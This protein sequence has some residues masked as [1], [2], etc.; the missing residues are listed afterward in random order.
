MARKIFSKS[1][2]APA[3]TRADMVRQRRNRPAAAA[4]ASV[5]MRSPQELLIARQRRIKAPRGSAAPREPGIIWGAVAA[6]PWRVHPLTLPKFEIGWRMASFALAA[7]CVSLLGYMLFSPIFFVGDI[8]LAGNTYVDAQEIAV[9]ANAHDMNILW[10]DPV[11]INARLAEIPGIASAKV[12]VDWPPSVAIEVVEKQPQLLWQQGSV[13]VWV[14]AAGDVFPARAEVAGLLPII[15]DDA[16]APLEAGQ[17]P[18]MAAI[19][20]ALQLRTLRPN[21]ELLHYETARGLSY[22]DGRNWRGYFGAGTDMQVKLSIYE[23]LVKNLEQR[24]IRP[25]V[26]SVENPQLPYYR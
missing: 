22:Q 21:I 1:G 26:I 14:D 9:A 18:P 6:I 3:V 10:L 25:R 7:L 2:P 4:A 24:G 16:V 11:Q 12:F 23:S 5:V 17:S 19:S 15:V 13:G 20:G 8:N